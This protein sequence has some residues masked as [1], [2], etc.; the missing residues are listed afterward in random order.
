MPPTSRPRSTWS[1]WRSAR[2]ST[3]PLQRATAPA[4]ALLLFWGRSFGGRAH[5]AQTTER[6]FGSGHLAVLALESA[7]AGPARGQK[8][9][10]AAPRRPAVALSSGFVTETDHE[11][12]A[13][14]H[15][16]H[17]RG[18]KLPQTRSQA[19]CCKN[20]QRFVR[21]WALQAPLRGCKPPHGGAQTGPGRPNSVVEPNSAAPGAP[22][23]HK[24]RSVFAENRA[25]TPHAPLAGA[26]GPTPRPRTPR[27]TNPGHSGT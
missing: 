12:P 10:E 18:P 20:H 23:P 8:P 24:P 13:A 7:A 6:A 17:T 5:A 26:P 22:A 1:S 25:R 15:P 11:G 21:S 14:P 3:A 2:S 4:V 19:V 9:P 27:Q 16:S